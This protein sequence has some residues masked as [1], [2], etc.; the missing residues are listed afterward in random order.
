MA[1]RSLPVVVQAGTPAA[2]EV[3]P[4]WRSLEEQLR[5][6]PDAAEVKAEFAVGA[7]LPPDATSRRTF[8]QLLGAS[9]ALAGLSGC[10]SK[11]REQMLPFTKQPEGHVAGKALHY[12][13]ASFLGGHATGLLVTSHDGRP[14]KIEGNPDHPSSRGGTGLL[15]QAQLLSL[16]DP[17]RAS[18][19]KEKGKDK[20]FRS[21]LAAQV[22]RA[23]ELK[24][25]EGAGLRFLMEPTSSPLIG[26]LRE[27]L[28]AEF[29]KAKFYAW[30]PLASDGA[31]EA[32]EA[33]F[34]GAIDVRHNLAEAAV[35]ASLDEDFLSGLPGTLGLQRD[36]AKGREPG[37]EMNRLYVIE[38]GLTPTG[39]HADHRA[40]AKPSELPALA[41]GLLGRVAR[42]SKAAPLAKFA[43]LN[44]NVGAHAKFL[45]ALAGDLVKHAGRSAVL[46]GARQPAAVHL[47]A[48]AI[49]AGLGNAGKTVSYAKSA[50]LDAESGPRGLAQ[51][52]AEIKAGKVDTL[53]ITANNPVYSAPADLDLEKLLKTVP[54]A[55]YLGA[56]EDETAPAVTWFVP[57][58]H[59]MEQWGDGRALDGT[60]TFAQPLI[61]PLF[62]G[63]S[64]AELLSSLL[65]EGEKGGLALLKAHW[66]KAATVSATTWEKWLSDGFAAGTA[67]PAAE[68]PK[69]DALSVETLKKA[70]PAAQGIEVFFAVDHK[71]YDGRF[72]NNAWLQEVPHPVT[73]L[74]WDNAA[75][76]AP[77]T[78]K[79][80]GLE[81][82]AVIDLKVKEGATERSI[83]SAV[84][85]Q[86]GQA[87]DTVQ[88]NLGYGRM[89]D[90]ASPA[91]SIAKDVGRNVT[92]LR[93]TTSFWSASGAEVLP[94]GH[95]HKLVTTQE[96]HSMEG[97]ALALQTT[98]EALE[99]KEIEHISKMAGPLP[100]MYEGAHAYTGLKW[101]MA[102]DLNKCTGCNACA[103]ACQAENNIS[104]V[105]K[106]QVGKS[107]EMHWLRVD[108]YY[109]GNEDAPEMITQPVMCVQCENA[110]C[111][112]VCPVNATVHSDEGLNV[113]V[114]NRCV[115]TRY[116]S[117][118]CP[119]KVRR[120]NFFSYT[121]SYTDVEKMVMNPDVTVRARGVMEKC[122]YCV[123]RIERVRIDTRVA[124]K[125]IKDGDI[126]TACQQACPSQAISF[127]TLS[128]PNSQV[129]KHHADPRRYDLLHDLGTRPRTAYLARVKNLNPELA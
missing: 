15:D 1:I 72:G 105:G 92:P 13:T 102:I 54:N 21:F 120:F 67:T 49:N 53:F 73:R 29:P 42:L 34:G 28:R 108:R 52:A 115:G 78:A 36:F 66:E 26:G 110:P 81:L 69:L 32:H 30:S 89:K 44:P 50:L 33:A 77:A 25:T 47:A 57:A 46:A 48:I 38:P 112:Y 56:Y 16:Y 43:D 80:L 100:T 35:V 4:L 22:A 40:I 107:R 99:K 116:C 2:P 60:V 96:H 5:G 104:V 74:S 59:A 113:M 19:I 94:V 88:L 126:V 7:D 8:V 55:V 121:S 87:Q 91:E 3:N 118:N 71:V 63:Q 79:R 124:G 111:E 129:S 39:G 90:A 11:T 12:A 41:L 103:I 106:E 18:V 128:D 76:I 122:T 65:G 37:H 84:L 62:G 117:N 125:E 98:L 127:G 64:P 101:A 31:T 45:D 27:R 119:Y 82:G 85:V 51:L 10:V 123:Q 68:Q 83:R 58:A 97:R 9:A 61:A 6:G 70:G 75:L 24:K 17:A 86:P 20:A 114:Y 109:I 14:T 93:S 95:E 23:A